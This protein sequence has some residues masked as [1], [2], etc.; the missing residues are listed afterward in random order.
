MQ[1]KEWNILAERFKSR[2]EITKW[3]KK[4]FIKPE[5]E[6]THPEIIKLA[7]KFNNCNSQ[8]SRS[9]VYLEC[10][11][12]ICE[13]E[14]NKFLAH[15]YLRGLITFELQNDEKD[16][17]SKITTIIDDIKRLLENWSLKDT[18]SKLTFESFLKMDKNS[19]FEEFNNIYWSYLNE[20]SKEEDKLREEKQRQLEIERRRN[21]ILTRQS[22]HDFENQGNFNLV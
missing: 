4:A 16:L 9:K 1:I 17:K 8:E 20:K 18:V 13:V 6:F 7:D 2:I 5:Y 14:Y 3:C 22:I 10:I 11:N 12:R 21:E 19:E 15:A